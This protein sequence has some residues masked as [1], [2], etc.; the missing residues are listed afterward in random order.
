MQEESAPPPIPAHRLLRAFYALEFLIAVI[1]VFTAWSEVGG[2]GHLDMMA[3][4]WKA[5]LA[6]AAAFAVV[7]ATAAAIERDPAWNG[8]TLKW[9]AITFVLLAGCGVITYYYHLYE[10]QDEDQDEDQPLTSMIESPPRRG[11]SRC[12]L[13]FAGPR[14]HC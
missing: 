14:P 10:P 3:W 9:I 12:V 8:R 11:V 5:G 7:K 6:G 2:Q 1:A 4:E 13:P